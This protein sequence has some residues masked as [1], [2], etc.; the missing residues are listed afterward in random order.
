M[1]RQQKSRFWIRLT[2]WEYW[3]IALANIPIVF[4]WLWY[5][6]RAR[7][8]FFF[9]AVNPAIPTGGVFGE[10]K[11]DILNRIPAKAIPLTV[12]SP[13]GQSIETTLQQMQRAGLEFPVVVKPNV[14]E[15]GL[16]VKRIAEPETFREH[17]L[18][19][20]IDWIIQELIDY[21]LEAS[22]LYYR[23][24]N[25]DQ[26]YIS[27]VCI[28]EF[29]SVIGD[30]VSTVERLM[31]QSDRAFLQIPRFRATETALLQSIPAAG[32]TCILEKIGNHSRGTK[33]LDGNQLINPSMVEAFHQIGRT[34]EGIYY[35]RFDLR[36]TSTLD[37]KKGQ[38]F[39][40]LEF[41]GVAGEPAHIYDP[42]VPI[43]EK[44]RIYFRHWS[45]IFQIY[46]Q[47][48]R[49]K[50][51]T[52]TWSELIAITRSYRA[53]LK[54]IQVGAVRRSDFHSDRNKK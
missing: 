40:I 52:M 43:L 38:N 33:F 18:A 5:A 54:T 30:G 45:I 8:L 23:F 34:M 48:K 44:Y 46:Q 51:P 14:G 35:G 15:R 37:L 10:A 28:K 26:G 27:S 42:A 3:P 16:L 47:Q 9:S 21:P 50:V 7:K 39:K 17:I 19:H 4:C 36:C 32:E 53:H 24:P 41:N 1:V 12:F 2:Q 31:A 13:Q 22:V 11:I 25:Q 49:Q 29:L 20:D 6:L